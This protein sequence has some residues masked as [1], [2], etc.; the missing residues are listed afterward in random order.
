MGTPGLDEAKLKAM[1]LQ[2]WRSAP[3][4]WP[5]KV[6]SLRR[7]AEIERSRH[8]AKLDSVG[9]YITVARAIRFKTPREMEDILGFAEGTFASGVSVWKLKSLPAPAQFDLRGYTQLPGGRPFDGIVLRRADSP[10]PQFFSRTGGSLEF[11]PGLAV[12][13]WELKPGLLLPALELQRVAPGA[14]FTAWF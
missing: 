4:L 1:V 6:I 10:R 7:L 11:I 8:G 13:Q 14:K 9:G 3:A 12:E 5:V 2:K